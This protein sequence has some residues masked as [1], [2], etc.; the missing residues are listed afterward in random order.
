MLLFSMEM[1][2]ENEMVTRRER[3]W[4]EAREGVTAE[5]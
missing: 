1:V 5:A 2:E 3:E 4:T